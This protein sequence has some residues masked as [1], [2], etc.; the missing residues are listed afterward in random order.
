MAETYSQCIS[1]LWPVFSRL[2]RWQYF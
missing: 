1:Q 2:D